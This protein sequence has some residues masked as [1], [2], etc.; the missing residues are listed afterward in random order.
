MVEGFF[1]ADEVKSTSRVSRH[2]TCTACG[3]HRVVT[4]PRL[5]PY[6]EFKSN[7]LIIGEAPDATENKSGHV[8]EGQEWRYLNHACN[9]LG[10]NLKKD[11]SFM[12]TDCM[13]IPSR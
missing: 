7:I 13:T 4:S 3:L 6:G 9:S 1:S 11:C 12:H 8:W 2:E 5:D 10:Y